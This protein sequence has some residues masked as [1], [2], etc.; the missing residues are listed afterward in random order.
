MDTEHMPFSGAIMY[1]ETL[2][3][4][5]NRNWF[6]MNSRNSREEKQAKKLRGHLKTSYLPV[7]FFSFD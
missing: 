7:T 1:L 3:Q 4:A 2:M 5:V 6:L